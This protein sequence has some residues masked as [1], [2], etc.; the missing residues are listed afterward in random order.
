[1]FWVSKDSLNS[2]NF[3]L[4][5]NKMDFADEITIVL[6]VCSSVLSISCKLVMRYI[7]VGVKTLH[8]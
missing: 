8:L 7:F 3:K 6:L 2:Y 1:M 4:Y 5:S